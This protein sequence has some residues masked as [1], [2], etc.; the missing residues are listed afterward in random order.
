MP[1]YRGLDRAEHLQRIRGKHFQVLVI[2]GGITGAGIAWD[3]ALRGLSV[4]LLERTDF[5]A[6][7]SSVS[8]KMVH[9]GLRYMVNDPQLVAEASAERKRLFRSCPHLAWPVEFLLPAYEDTPE[10]DAGAL[11][12]VLARYDELAGNDNTA[13]GRLLDPAR[14]L[15]DIPQ[16]RRGALAVGSYWDGLMDDARLTLEVIHSAA[17]AGAVVANHAPV[18]GF[19]EDSAGRVV[20]ARFRDEDPGGPGGEDRVTADAVVCAAGVYTDLLLGLAGQEHPVLRPSKG[21]HIVFRS[22]VTSGKALTVPVGG[23][24]LYFLVPFRPGYLAMGCTDT[25]YPVDGYAALDRVPATAQEMEYTLGLLEKVLPG[26]FAPGQVVA[27]YAGVRPLLAPPQDRSLSASDTSRTHRIWQARGGI[28]AVAGG[29]TTTFRLMAEQLAD[30][31][32]E[33]LGSRFPAL[34]AQPC[35]TA[36]RTC[37]GAPQPGEPGA[38]PPDVASGGWKAWAEREAA[39]LGRLAG[40]PP[41][42]CRHLVSAYGTS[43]VE[44]AS[45]ARGDP[46]LGGRIAA[47]RPF[48]RAEIRYAAEREM[49]RSAADFLARRSQLRFLEHQ[50]LDAVDAVVDGL[51]AC[52][53][54]GPQTRRGQAE[55]YREYIRQATAWRLS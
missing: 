30:R 15:A 45:L 43:A 37:H 40:L 44:V 26:V 7:T 22:E 18:I 25:D 21:I 49:C 20:G 41:D 8:S 4:A 38:S 2:G 32:V 42:C 23:R 13:P 27:C 11:P 3:C 5:A 9:A 36:E 34:R 55:E 54:W 52:L 29:K 28:W 35:T 19:L 51:A 31:V 48:V 33:D 53:G 39:R 24:V 1:E 14:V 12:G 47:G 16:L 10:F 46:A 50:G 6:G 17:Q